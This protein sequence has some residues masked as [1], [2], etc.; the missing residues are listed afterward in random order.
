MNMRNIMNM[1]SKFQICK[2]CGIEVGSAESYYCEDCGDPLCLDCCE[3][4]QQDCHIIFLF[5]CKFCFFK[6]QTATMKIPLAPLYRQKEDLAPA[7]CNGC[8]EGEKD[9]L[10]KCNFCSDNTCDYCGEWD[11]VKKES[12]SQW[13]VYDYCGDCFSD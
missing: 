4:V 11:I 2:H 1:S 8:G 6:D 3:M 9:R 12:D 13:Y 7:P 10:R 5:Y